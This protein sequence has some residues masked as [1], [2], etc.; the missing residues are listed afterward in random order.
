M[1]ILLID[2]NCKNSSTGKIVHDLY[3]GIKNSGN[4]AAICYGRG[5]IINGNNILKFGLDWETY[6]HAFLTRLLGFTGCYS[7]FSTKRLINFIKKFKPDLVHIH[8]LHAYFVNIKPLLKYLADLGLPIVWTFHCE[9]M[10]TGK[11]GHAFDCLGFLNECGNC[12][13]LHDYPK[14]FF[15]DQTKYMFRKKRE[16]FSHLMNITIVTPSVWLANRVRMSFLKD[17]N[18]QVIHNGID[19]RMFYPRE[20]T[21]LK[22][23]L[24]IIDGQR[25]VLSVAP[26]IMSEQKGGKYVIKLAEI[27]KKENIKFILVGADDANIPH[28]SNTIILPRTADQNELAELYSLADVFVICSSRENLPTTCLEAQCCGTPVCG[29]EA[30]GAKETAVSDISIF[31]SYGD[32]DGLKS[33]VERVLLEGFDKLS[34]ANESNKIYSKKTMIDNYQSIY[35]KFFGDKLLW[36]NK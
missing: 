17:R 19:T 26:G 5:P 3:S 30:G 12:P 20:T 9:F 25:V 1:K 27:M 34:L 14:S 32:L 31:V 6:C 22:K 7:Y 33:A 21:L 29:F 36:V 8:E 4:E 35:S 18:I 28:P 2:V 10:Y 23:K 15:F 24:E 13:Q 16:L 11:C